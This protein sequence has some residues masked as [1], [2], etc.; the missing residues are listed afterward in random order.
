M[1][2]PTDLPDD[3]DLLKAMI[4]ASKADI[5]ARDVRLADQNASIVDRDGIIERK[6]DRIQCL[7]KLVADFTRALFGAKSEKVD[8]EQ[9]ELALEDIETAMAA[10]HAEDEAVDTPKSKQAPRKPN[11]GHLPKHLP[12]VGEVIEPEDKTCS[13]GA[14]RHIIGEDISERLDI[15]PAQ[16]RVIITRRPKYACRSRDTG[17]VLSPAKPSLIEDGMPTEATVASVI[18]SKY[19]DHLPL[20]RQAQIY[21][22]QGVDLD[23]STLTSWVGKA[24]Y[25]L[26]PV[27]E[28]LLANLKQS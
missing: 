20:Y 8:P 24:A 16:F 25:E 27:Y 14:E 19:A 2:N 26:K 18:V 22:R 28:C 11:R 9:Y 1:T 4:L 21:S 6:E 17:I 3:I 7:E 23:R 15:I 10:I 13:C 5:A 12:R